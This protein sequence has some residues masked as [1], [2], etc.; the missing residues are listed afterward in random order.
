MTEYRNIRF[1]YNSLGCTSP[2]AMK[3]S[4]R[5]FTG[6]APQYIGLANLVAWPSVSSDTL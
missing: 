1:A 6:C 3:S 4:R 5:C 2:A